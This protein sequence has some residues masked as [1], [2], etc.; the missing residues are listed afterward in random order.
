MGKEPLKNVRLREASGRSVAG[1]DKI[2]EEPSP[3]LTLTPLDARRLQEK[4]G[5]I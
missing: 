5:L 1:R 4:M 2:L 3:L